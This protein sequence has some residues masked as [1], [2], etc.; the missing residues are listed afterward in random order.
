[1]K[2]KATLSL[3][4][5]CYSCP[6][7]RMISL[8]MICI[9]AL[10]VVM[11]FIT[12]SYNSLIILLCSVTASV[13][14][15]VLDKIL[16]RKT[17]PNIVMSIVIGILIGMFFPALYPPFAAF[18]TIFISLVVFKYS[19]GGISS[20][21]LNP[22]SITIIIAYSV[23]SIWFHESFLSAEMIQS[24]NTSLLLIQD[25]TLPIHR[26]DSTITAFLNKTIF[27]HLGTTIPEGYISLLW[28]NGSSIPAFRFNL[29]T[30]L[31]SIVLLSLNMIN[32]IVPIC[33]LFF[34][35]LLV[36]LFCPV[37]VGGSFATGDILLS[38]LTSGTLFTAF[39]VLSWFGTVPFTN[40]GKILYGL[41]AGLAAFFICG[42]GLSSA[43]AMFS[44]FVANVVSLLLQSVEHH[45]C[46]MERG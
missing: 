30:L 4:P 31:G 34:Y 1:M 41:L 32:C 19:F 24:Q 37:L 14:S 17:N 38:L 28:D 3:K 36:R 46:K 44:V 7:L 40:T 13:L 20:S 39:F 18:C 33:F 12:K 45:F 43:G 6:S 8:A 25:G 15:E 9:L 21:W 10:Q 23:G 35:S 16:I 11:L 27:S 5:F 29:L 26:F 22:V 42:Y 2:N